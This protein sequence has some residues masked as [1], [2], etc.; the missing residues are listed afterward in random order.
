MPLRNWRRKRLRAK[1]FPAAWRALLER[2]LP[3]YR[4]LPESDR[5]ELEGHTRVLLAEKY[6][7][8][9]AGLTLTDE[10]RV[11]IAAQA[12]VLLLHRDTNYYPGVSTILVYPAAYLAQMRAV[13]PAGIVTEG[14]AWRAGES[15]HTPGGRQPVV[16]SWRDVQA[17]AAD[18]GDGSNVVFHEFAHQLDGET[19]AVDGAPL[20]GSREHAEEWAR[21]MW[22]EYHALGADLRSGRPTLL[23]PYAA[24]SPAEFF[25][26]LTEVFFERGR[27]LRERH[28][29]AYRLMARYFRQ[30]PAALACGETPCRESR[31]PA[32]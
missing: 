15:W 27:E 14:A 11:L 20:M 18:P 6:Y 26:V 17:G 9:C 32:A 22:R 30:D 3:Y 10:V 1:A 24:T 29:E 31:A 2:R 13:G 12:A 19:G 16:V 4:C 8:G 21:V 25:A 28:P 5:R 23:S 7:E